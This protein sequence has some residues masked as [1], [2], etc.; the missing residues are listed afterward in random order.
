MAVAGFQHQP[1]ASS[2]RAS[3]STR[4]TIM[5]PIFG[6]HM[7]K[8]TLAALGRAASHS[9]RQSMRGTSSCSGLSIEIDMVSTA[10]TDGR[11]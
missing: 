7:K 3:A 4:S 1:L 9:D 11:R 5:A 2:S 8:R 6:G 10:T